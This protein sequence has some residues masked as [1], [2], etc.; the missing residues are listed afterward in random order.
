MSRKFIILV[1]EDDSDDFF[2]LQRI[3]SKAHVGDVHHVEDG[4]QA[5][6]YLAG[7]GPFHD[8]ERHPYPDIL[9]LDLKLPVRTGHQVLEWLSGQR[10]IPRPA[11][12]VL[13]GSFSEVEQRRAERAGAV[14]FFLKPLSLGHVAALVEQ[15]AVAAL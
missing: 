3:L 9:L 4:Q 6:D 1:A 10:A 8:R 13:S 7:H 5:I 11:T 2:F 14:G 12:Y 15:S